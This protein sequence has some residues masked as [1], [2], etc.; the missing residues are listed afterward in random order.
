MTLN[1]MHILEW[2]LGAKLVMVEVASTVSFGMLLVW[3]LWKE[4]ER[5]FGSRSRVRHRRVAVRTH[6]NGHLIVDGPPYQGYCSMNST[7]AL[8]NSASTLRCSSTALA[9]TQETERAN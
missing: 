7:L 4:Y 1:T 8:M 9:S 2:F 6:K 3:L 5:L